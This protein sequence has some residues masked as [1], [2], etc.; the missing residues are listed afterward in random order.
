MDRRVN[1][2]IFGWRAVN[3]GLVALVSMVNGT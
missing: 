2:R 1:C 3:V